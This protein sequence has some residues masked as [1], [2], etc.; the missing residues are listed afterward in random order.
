[1]AKIRQLIQR[2]NY[3]AM[4]TEFPGIVAKPLGN[5]KNRLLTSSSDAM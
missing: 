2:Y 3:V 4:D 5:F 1:M